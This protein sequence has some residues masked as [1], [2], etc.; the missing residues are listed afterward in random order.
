ML[1]RSRR[2][3]HEAIKEVSQH[4]SK[5]YTWVIDADIKGYFDNIPHKRLMKKVRE[6]IADGKILHIINSFLK[7]GIL[8]DMQEWIPTKGTPQGGVLSPLLANIYLH[9]LDLLIDAEGCKIIR[10]ADDFVVLCQSEQEAKQVMEIIEKWMI[11]NGLELHPEKTKIC[12]CMNRDKGFEFL[13]YSFEQGYKFVRKKSLERLKSKIREK[14]KRTCG[15]NIRKVIGELNK[16]LIG[17]FN[18][19]KYAQGDIYRKTDALIRRRL[20]AIRRKQ[21]KRPGMGKTNKDH[22]QWP[23][24]YFAN[25]GLFSLTAARDMFNKA[26]QPR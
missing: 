11:D 17:W 23:N 15:K 14:T 5:G 1:F 7:A 19:F 21:K 2:N 10:Y 26:N 12:N 24:E 4:I 25:L 6:K 22:K 3:A 9:E 20:R 18:Y 16:I 13:G 8:E